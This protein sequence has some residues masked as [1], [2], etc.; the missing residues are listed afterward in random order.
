MLTGKQCPA[1]LPTIAC[2]LRTEGTFYNRSRKVEY[3]ADDVRW[4]YDM[5]ERHV[6][7]PHRFVCL[8]DVPINYKR[9][10]RVPLIWDWSGWWAKIEL[11]RPLLFEGAVL[12]LDLDTAVIDNIDHFLTLPELGDF[13]M[14][15]SLSR[16]KC[17]GRTGDYGSGVLAFNG[18]FSSLYRDF[19]HD[20]DTHMA[21]YTVS[22]RWGDQG[23][24]GEH[25]S[26][27]KCLQ[28]VYPQHIQS[29]KYDYLVT[30]SLAS[31]KILCF[32]GKPKPKE[33]QHDWLPKYKGA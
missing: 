29:Y 8:S 9:I 27:I 26:N 13:Y 28:D 33:V 6:T 4:L 24:I 19:A 12:Y 3:T 11:F 25:Q 22:D 20:A 21:T 17:K 5:V 18:D 23:F 31:V 15:R 16:G 2:V 32:H 7:I 10:E 30:Q 14:L 1:K